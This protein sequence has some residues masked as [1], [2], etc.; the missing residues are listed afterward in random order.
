MSASLRRDRSWIAVSYSAVKSAATVVP[1][2]FDALDAGRPAESLVDEIADGLA[3]VNIRSLPPVVQP[4]LLAQLVLAGEWSAEQAVTE[5]AIVEP[6]LRPPLVASLLA[7][8]PPA[9]Q[10]D[11][12]DLLDP[13]AAARVADELSP[14]PAPRPAGRADLDEAL[15]AEDCNRLWELLKV[16]PRLPEPLRA[17]GVRLTLN[18]A[19][20]YE[21]EEYEDDDDRWPT[22]YRTLAPFLDEDQVAAALKFAEPEVVVALGSRLD[23]A[24]LDR[25]LADEGIL[26]DLAPHLG[27]AHAER[28]VG[29]AT[30]IRHL[31]RR[32]QVLTAL[33]PRLEEPRR[34]EV[35]RLALAAA[36]AIGDDVEQVRLLTALA[37]RLAGEERAAALDRALARTLALE[38]DQQ[39]FETLKPLIAHLD[40]AQLERALAAAL[41]MP[42]A[43]YRLTALAELAPRLGRAQLDRVLA[44][45]AAA[46]RRRANIDG[47][48][49]G[50][51]PYLDGA[52][53]D[54]ALAIA[55]ALAGNFSGAGALAG[56]AA[57]L[58]PGQRARAISAALAKPA[59]DRFHVLQH[60]LPGLEGAERAAVLEHARS[61]AE[62]IEFP[63]PRA[64]AMAHLRAYLPE[65]SWRDA[66]LA[67]IAAEPDEHSRARRLAELAP[68][69]DGPQLDGALAAA[70]ALTRDESRA[71]AL[72]GLAAHLAGDALERACDAVFGLPPGQGRSRALVRLAAVLSGDRRA[73]AAAVALADA[74][75]VTDEFHRWEGL[76]VVAPCLDRD[77]LAEVLAAAAALPGEGNR[78]SALAGLAAHLDADQLARACTATMTVTSVYSRSDTL[79]ALARHAPATLLPRIAAA[80][81]LHGK[82]MVAVARR[83]AALADAPE[84][85]AAALIV[86]RAALDGDSRATALAVLA[87]LVGFVE[88][89]AG[90]DAVVRLHDAVAA[91]LDRCP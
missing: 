27:A 37:T 91:I 4:E 19:E 1:M 77:G 39:R 26:A 31:N 5:I 73:R 6:R 3:V 2:Q 78:A 62:A 47:A 40:G 71:T 59:I 23:D 20:A 36:T 25:A 85:R 32:V 15:A 21:P 24:Q 12:L 41:E 53:L 42:H 49:A 58:G 10:A 72:V 76:I 81:G 52:Q 44:V 33:A 57:H 89:T 14:P 70:L 55:L 87:E 64:A 75:A 16:V 30:A 84:A 69:L 34:G 82:A 35:V 29:V 86:L 38:T 74:L 80:A 28:A 22:V 17:E 45:V 51:A 60:M 13:E 56:V 66:I 61:A 48:L 18:A 68:H 54:E 46:D 67:A 65:P 88:T 9:L 11:A 79:G 8:L 7:H 50:I 83:A 90:P 63:A 43:F